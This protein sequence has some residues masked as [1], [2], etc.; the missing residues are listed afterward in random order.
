MPSLNNRNSSQSA[1]PN[2]S[3]YVTPYGE[4]GVSSGLEA[5]T[6]A[7]NVSAQTEENIERLRELYEQ[8]AFTY[9]GAEE[10]ASYAPREVI[11]MQADIAPRSR[12]YT[13]SLPPLASRNV[14]RRV[15]QVRDFIER[16][17]NTPQSAN[18][19]P[20]HNPASPNSL[21]GMRFDSAFIEEE[22]PVT[23]VTHTVASSLNRAS[24]GAMMGSIV[25]KPKGGQKKEKLEHLVDESKVGMFWKKAL[26]E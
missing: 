26:G 11:V 7:E 13:I 23:T 5:A 4:I 9:S 6:Q 20:G 24:I 10:P 25:Q 15:V 14:V 16:R 1:N 17:Q 22:Y 12:T 2:Q 21:R 3:S 18:T 8:A 19:S